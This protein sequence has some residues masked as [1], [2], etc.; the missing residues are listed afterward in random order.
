MRSE[1]KDY[2]SYSCLVRKNV[3]PSQRRLALQHTSIFNFSQ[4]F[5]D[6]VMRICSTT[7]HDPWRP[8]CTSRCTAKEPTS[9]CLLHSVG[10]WGIV[11]YSAALPILARASRTTEKLT[12]VIFA[13]V[14][15]HASPNTTKWHRRG[16]RTFCRVWRRVS[17]DDSPYTANATLTEMKYTSRSAC[18][19]TGA[20][21]LYRRT[22]VYGPTTGCSHSFYL[23][24]KLRLVIASC[25]SG[26]GP[27]CSTSCIIM[28]VTNSLM[29][30][31]VESNDVVTL[32][33]E[34]LVLT[35]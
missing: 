8:M 20:K 10:M 34:L 33:C 35:E 9:A 13:R 31:A 2:K 32:G 18:S 5:G 26:V 24:K 30:C 17:N 11:L 27:S 6:D 23:R 14:R 15:T 25:Q 12:S 28:F 7:R 29:N 19:R 22:V 16:F 1:C 3:G 4:V 21:P